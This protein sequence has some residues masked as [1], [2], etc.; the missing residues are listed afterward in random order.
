MPARSAVTTLPTEVKEWLDKCLVESDF[1][2]YEALSAALAEKGFQ[3]S[4]SSLH[5]YGS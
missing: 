2:G 1:S 3:I 5:R 4:K